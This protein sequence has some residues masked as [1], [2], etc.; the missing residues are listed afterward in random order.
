MRP[1]GIPE[2]GSYSIKMEHCFVLAQDNFVFVRSKMK[3][4]QSYEFVFGLGSNHSN[5]KTMLLLHLL[6][7]L[8]YKL[9]KLQERKEIVRRCIHADFQTKLKSLKFIER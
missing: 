2:C 4:S 9:F 5:R 6:S 1:S 3:I 8:L 7:N